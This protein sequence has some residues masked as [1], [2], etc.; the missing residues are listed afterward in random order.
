MSEYQ[1]YD[2]G[3]ADFAYQSVYYKRR[4]PV[5][6]TALIA[7]ITGI[8]SLA[9][10]FFAWAA[11][12]LGLIAIVVALISKNSFGGFDKMSRIG[13]IFGIVG[14]VAGALILIS[15]EIAGVDFW[16]TLLEI[17]KE[18]YGDMIPDGGGSTPG[19]I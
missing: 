13:F 9:F 14:I 17:F 18:A 8:L 15:L 6:P 4:D 5:N 10:S 11:I 7:M 1:N 12:A 16:Q 3:G 19:G 2:N